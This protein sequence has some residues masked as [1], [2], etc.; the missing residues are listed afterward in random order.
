MTTNPLFNEEIYLA[1]NPE[2]AKDIL[3]DRIYS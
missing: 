3:S 2:V 1:L